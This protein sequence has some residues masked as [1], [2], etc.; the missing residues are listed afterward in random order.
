[1]VQYLS[2][3]LPDVEVDCL[4]PV[5]GRGIRLQGWLKHMTQQGLVRY[6]PGKI[7]A[8]DILACWLDHLCLA[9]TKPSQPTYLIGID[10]TWQ[11]EPVSAQYAMEQLVA[12]MEGYDCGLTQP[13][14]YFPRTAHAGIQACID[15]KGQW[16]DDEATL[17]KAAGKR[18]EA[19]NGGYM[20]EGEGNNSYIYRVWPQWDDEVAEQLQGWEAQIL[21]PAVMQLRE[22]EQG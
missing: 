1:M 2:Q 5:S 6:R 22:A 15:K 16:C 14:P 21:Q 10:G 9:V 18:A 7:R 12:L 8:Q 3:P 20:F 11:L 13:L 4:V 19:F 17:S